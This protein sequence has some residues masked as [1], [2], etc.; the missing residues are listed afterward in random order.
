METKETQTHDEMWNKWDK[1]HRRGK[2]IGGAVIVLIGALFLARE[3]G[4]VFPAWFFTWKMLIIAIGL[5]IGIKHGFRDAKWLIPVAVGSAFLVSDLFPELSIRPFLWPLMIIAFG[6]FI[7]FKPHHRKHRAWR[8]WKREEKYRRHCENNW[9]LKT[10]SNNEDTVDFTS[11]MGGIKKN[12]LSK[13][14]KRGDVTVVFAGTEIN[15]SQADFHEKAELDLT[16]VFGGT[17]LIV[18]S[19]WEIKSEVVCVFGSVEDKRIIQ[20]TTTTENRKI[21]TLRGTVFMGG[22]EIK[23]Y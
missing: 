3:I 15:F 4:V 11:F 14:F 9:N 12:I 1:E 17:L 13:N 22:I 16:A 18:P 21:L 19:N 8:R 20:P 7:I 10:E 23:N 2:R 6:L 5:I